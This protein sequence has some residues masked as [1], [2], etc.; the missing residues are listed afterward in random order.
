MD[1]ELCHHLQK[2]RCRYRYKSSARVLFV[3]SGADE[4]CAG[5]G[6]HKTKYR[7][8]GYA[9]ILIG[10]CYRSV[11]LMFRPLDCQGYF[12]YFATYGKFIDSVFLIE[13]LSMFLS[14][15]C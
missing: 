14:T 2:D 13:L 6:R 10:S 1:G 8:G 15:A 12:S 7:Q 4:Q 3:G 5:Y 11:I 9:L